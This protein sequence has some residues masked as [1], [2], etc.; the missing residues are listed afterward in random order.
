MYRQAYQ[1]LVMPM[2]Q[3]VSPVYQ[4]TQPGLSMIQTDGP[5]FRRFYQKVLSLVGLATM[6]LSVFVAIYS[7][8][9][10]R[11]LLGRRWIDAG[12]ILTIL[13]FGTFIKQPVSS[14][15]FILI[16]RGL[17]KTYFTLTVVQNIVFVSLMVLGVHWGARGVAAA[18]VATTY[19][20]I[21]PYLYFCLKGSPVSVGAFFSALSRPAVASFVMA[22]ALLLLR[23][24][25]PNLSLTGSL[26]LGCSLAAVVFPAAWMLMPGGNREFLALVSDVRSALQKKAVGVGPSEAAVMAN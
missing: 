17:S 7:T 5:R 6:P 13:S 25:Q 8:E 15:A 3:L 21:G 19:L 26:A 22:A 11:V 16:T 4:V 9:I 2:E 23:L 12:P 10:T 14:A 20:L 18:D 24:A 1:L